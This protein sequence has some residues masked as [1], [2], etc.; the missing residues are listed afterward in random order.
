MARGLARFAAFAALTL[1]IGAALETRVAAAT[2][3]SVARKY[4]AIFAPESR[5]DGIVLGCSLEAHGVDPRALAGTGQHWYNFAYSGAGPGF[6]RGWY[7]LFHAAGKRAKVALVAADW[8][9]LSPDMSRHLE[10]DASYWPWPVVGQVLADPGH[11][12]GLTLANAFAVSRAR[13]DVQRR[14]ALVRLPREFVPLEDDFHD[15]WV[16]VTGADRAPQAPAFKQ[17]ERERGAAAA[18]TSL[19]AALEADGTRVVVLRMPELQPYAGRHPAELA[20]WRALVGRRPLL[21]YTDGRA[22]TLCHDRGSF[23]DWA[24]L[25][26]R[27]AA[28]FGAMLAR[29]MR[30]LGVGS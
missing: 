11:Q 10:H 13:D 9:L 15:G 3:G 27:G 30:A 2:H 16:P 28:A 14:F 7:E 8:F 12:P 5:Y 25:N 17:G 19:L 22:D 21:D 1:A 29:D 26:G 6:T 24:H 20:T 18:F 23:V 4:E